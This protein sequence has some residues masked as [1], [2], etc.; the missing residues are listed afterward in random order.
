LLPALQ[1]CPADYEG[2]GKEKVLQHLIRKHA[3]NREAIQ[4]DINLWHDGEP[5]SATK[6]GSVL[7]V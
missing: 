5:L 1:A 7:I 2:Y 6:H 3:G 4:Q